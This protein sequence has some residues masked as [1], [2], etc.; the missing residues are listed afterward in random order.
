MN[1]FIDYRMLMTSIVRNYVV[2]RI[3]IVDKVGPRRF[4]SRRARAP[5]VCE[6]EIA[7]IF[8]RS[9]VSS[10]HHKFADLPHVYDSSRRC[11]GWIEATV[12]THKNLARLVPSN[13]KNPFPRL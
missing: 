13:L 3:N 12:M 7:I 8:L 1:W 5:P 2:Q 10:D 6:G 4:A 9:P 11:K